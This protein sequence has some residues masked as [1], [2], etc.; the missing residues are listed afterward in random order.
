LP[1]PWVPGEDTEVG[2]LERAI[3]AKG[4]EWGGAGEIIIGMLVGY[5]GNTE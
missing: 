4:G 5:N 3:V 1:R 2:V